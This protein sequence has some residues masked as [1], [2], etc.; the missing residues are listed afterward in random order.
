MIDIFLVNTEFP[1]AEGLVKKLSGPHKPGA[2]LLLTDDEMHCFKHGGAER[3]T[4]PQEG[5]KNENIQ[6]L[7]MD[8]AKTY[9]AVVRKGCVN[10]NTIADLQLCGWD[11]NVIETM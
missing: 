2:I 3:I 9:I 7:E 11:I 1:G 4:I 8:R 5:G 10:Q 6:L